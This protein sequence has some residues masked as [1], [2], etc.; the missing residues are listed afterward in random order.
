M[1]KKGGSAKARQAS[2]VCATQS[3]TRRRHAEHAF[4][5]AEKARRQTVAGRPCPAAQQVLRH[6][7]HTRG[8]GNGGRHGAQRQ[9]HV[10]RSTGV[11]VAAALFAPLRASAAADPSGARAHAL[12]EMP[13][14]GGAPAFPS[15]SAK[16]SLV[17][18]SGVTQPKPNPKRQSRR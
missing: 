7:R 9:Q 17:F 3:S 6:C 18:I 4:A 10:A 13:T 14:G 8:E 15:P 16:R 12:P 1:E 11:S 5:A 2:V